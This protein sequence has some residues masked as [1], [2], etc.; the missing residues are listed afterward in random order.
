METNTVILKDKLVKTGS[1]PVFDE[2]YN[3][4]GSIHYKFLSVKGKVEIKDT[5]ENLV[6]KGGAKL[7]SLLPKWQITSG[8]GDEIGTIKRKPSLFRKKYSY[9]NSQGNTYNIKGSITDRTFDVVN[10]RG[11]RVIQVFSIS[12]IISLRPH[13]FA[14]EINGKEFST[15][16]AI[17]LVQGIRSLVKREQKSKQNQHDV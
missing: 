14:V 12:S 4:I 16:E 2:S 9:R 13:T 6:S 8:S 1:S 10:D 3:E 15:W 11:V 7:V 5:S 17:N